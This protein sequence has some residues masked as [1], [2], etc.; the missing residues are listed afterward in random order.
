MTTPRL[1]PK[2]RREQLLKVALQVAEKNPHYTFQNVATA[3][4]VT[5]PLVTRYL[6]NKVQMKRDVMRAAVRQGVVAIV[7]HGLLV[8][9]PHAKKAPP[10]LR[11]K[12]NEYM[13]KRAAV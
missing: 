4:G 3:A 10:E 8:G 6:G 7:A 5:V 2:D 12:I 1:D 9:D 13:A 11:V